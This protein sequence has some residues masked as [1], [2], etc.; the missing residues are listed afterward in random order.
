MGVSGLML[1]PRRTSCLSSP[2]SRCSTWW[3]TSRAGTMFYFI[4][5]DKNAPVFQTVRLRASWAAVRASYRSWRRGTVSE[6]ASC[7]ITRFLDPGNHRNRDPER[8]RWK[9]R[10]MHPPFASRRDPAASSS[11]PRH[12]PRPPRAL[13]TAAASTVRDSRRVRQE[14]RK[15]NRGMLRTGIVFVRGATVCGTKLENR[16]ATIGKRTGRLIFDAIV[17]GSR[18]RAGAVAT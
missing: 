12:A 8:R 18:V 1:C 15:R 10:R 17:V 9:L 2:G 4:N 6:A 7:R 3:N 5:K 11:R 16:N 14:L 13:R